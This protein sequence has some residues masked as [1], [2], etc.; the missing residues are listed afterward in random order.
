[1]SWFWNVE[2]MRKFLLLAQ[3]V[4]HFITFSVFTIGDY[5]WAWYKYFSSKHGKGF[6]SIIPFHIWEYTDKD[7]AQRHT[8]KVRSRPTAQLDSQAMCFSLCDMRDC[9]SILRS[10]VHPTLPSDTQS[11]R[12][13]RQKWAGA[14]K[15]SCSDPG[16]VVVDNRT[17][18]WYILRDLDVGVKGKKMRITA[19]LRP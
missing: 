11:E 19:K 14:S 13:P 5:L 18:S 9:L 16:S 17:E 12:C 8:A 4:C 1:M 6:F 15:A 10:T 3:N 2:L 7:L